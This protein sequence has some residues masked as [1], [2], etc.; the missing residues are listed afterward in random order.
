[1]KVSKNLIAGA[2]LAILESVDSGHIT[3]TV[4]MPSPYQN[5]VLEALIEALDL[6]GY[7]VGDGHEE[8]KNDLRHIMAE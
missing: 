2:A 8:M 5:T 4:W 7:S 3:D 6:A 1:M